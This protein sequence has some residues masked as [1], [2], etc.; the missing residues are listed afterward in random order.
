M[1]S[2]NV[3]TP[4]RSVSSFDREEEEAAVKPVARTGAWSPFLSVYESADGENLETAP[5]REAYASLVN[6]LYDEEFDEAL[7][8]LLNEARGLHDAQ[9]AS[10]RPEAEADRVV[11][12]H[13]A[14][15]MRESEAMVEAVAREF[16]GRDDE[17]VESEID[18]F[19]ERLAPAAG[20]TPSF[21]DFLG[22]YARKLVK[23]VTKVAAAVGKVALGP[24]M[25][26]VKLIGRPI[27]KQVLLRAIGK[28]PPDLQPAAH[29]L[30]RRLGFAVAPKPAP[31]PTSAAVS[32]PVG[33]PAPIAEPTATAAPTDGS[34]APPPAGD[35]G[36]AVQGDAAADVSEMQFEFDE[37]LAE[38]LLAQDEAALEL[39]MG[40]A[41]SVYGAAERPV[42]ADLD[43]ARERLIQDLGSLR[44]GESPEPH[45]Q[46]FLPAVLPALK[47]GIKA[48][49]R[50]RLIDTI[51]GVV[52]QGIG[53]LTDPTKAP[54]LS[55]AIVDA[56]LKLLSLELSEEQEARLAPS[57]IVATVEET[58][59]RVTSLP[60]H[61]LEDQTLLE[62]F[63]LQAFEQSAA[64]NLPAV[65]SAATYRRRPDLLE[66]GVNA[67]W[68]LWPL[69]RPRY[70][71]C[72]RTF[73][74]RITPQMAEAIET[75]EDSRL[76]D[77]FHDQLGV[78]EGEDVEAEVHLFETIAGGTAGDVA[79]LDGEMLGFGSGDALE[80][81][82]LQ[83]LTPEAAEVLLGK[84]GLGRPVPPGTSIMTVPTGQRLYA[85]A[86]RRPL[87][88]P[89]ATG[90]KRVRRLAHVSVTL[91][92]TND[93]LRVC[94]YLSEVKAQRLAVRLR[95]QAHAGSLAVSLNQMLTRRLPPILQGR[96]PRRLRL[97]HAALPPGPARAAARQRLA[98]LVP[99]TF[100][101][102][103]QQSLVQAFSEF[104]KTGA[105]TFMTAAQD[106]SDGVTVQ[107]TAERFPG[108]KDIG[109]ALA[110]RGLA[111]VAQAA[112][113]VQGAVAVT[114]VAL[115]GHRCG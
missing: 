76:S 87:T 51:A 83:P 88:V 47:L 86:G 89:G 52:S 14:E 54:A 98:A 68:V 29:Q 60:D 2:A 6:E 73:N 111:P 30:A 79:R 44:E 102:S 93:R 19:V 92:W 67:A 27:L 1:A 45:I 103:V 9:L 11:T 12:Q 66:G 114:V 49:G 56:G 34:L 58:L 4:F 78:D 72:S 20:L 53:R 15:L 81:S 38:V 21:E 70:K 42:F 17:V 65:F 77:F 62:G 5:L 8:E 22:R 106:P 10:G 91:D 63:T 48:F 108:L 101:A 36:S 82:Q 31:P 109:T 32:P 26:Q 74:V 69:Q 18:S 95:Q 110:G 39:E 99:P 55:R 46:N 59:S 80:V 16:G 37:R 24:I 115:P 13:F 104:V 113:V 96:R 3:T 84:P 35:A 50:K 41:M 61:V 97:V 57:A 40:R 7:F 105:Q 75:F 28:L 33:E 43:R 23:G 25:A 64:A 85:I 94:L 112:P 100:I 90:R 71:R 107:F